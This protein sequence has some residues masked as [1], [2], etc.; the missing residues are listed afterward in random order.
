MRGERRLLKFV[1]RIVMIAA[2]G[3]T[4]L[5]TLSCEGGNVYM[6]VSVAGPY[7]GYPYGGGYPYRGGGVYVGRPVYRH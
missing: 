3:W 7:A 4:V 1:V 5:A 6:G 2:I